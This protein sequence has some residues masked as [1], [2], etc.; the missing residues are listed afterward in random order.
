[1]FIDPEEEPVTKPRGSFLL[2]ALAWSLP[3]L[4]LSVLPLVVMSIALADSGAG[5][6]S[7]LASP[8]WAFA[9][10]VL[11]GQTVV[12]FIAGITQSR[13]GNTA[14]VMLCVAAV[15]VLGLVPSLVVLAFA[16]SHHE[17]TRHVPVFLVTMQICLFLLSCG[18]FL[19]LGSLGE[20][21]L[22]GESRKQ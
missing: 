16:V 19:V 22:H 18:V 2:Q 15:L 14:I 7:I 6:G 3:E 5:G 13:R 8:E 1:M 11:F 10:S 20:V 17:S 21:L 4:L 12:R 9:A